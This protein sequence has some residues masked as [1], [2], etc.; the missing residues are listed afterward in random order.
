MVVA[1]KVVKASP[2]ASKDFQKAPKKKSPKEN[3]PKKPKLQGHD[4]RHS[5]YMTA[6]IMFRDGTMD[7]NEMGDN[8]SVSID[9]VIDHAKHYADEHGGVSI[10]YECTP[11]LVVRRPQASVEHIDELKELPADV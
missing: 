5:F 7:L 3:S 1:S 10:I 4:P 11:M 9:A 8:A 6:G 2:K